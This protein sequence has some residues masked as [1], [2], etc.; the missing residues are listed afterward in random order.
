MCQR[1]SE[2]RHGL[3]FRKQALDRV[4][5]VQRHHDPIACHRNYALQLREVL[6]S[7]VGQ[8]AG[9]TMFGG[10]GFAFAP[11]GTLLA[12]TSAEASLRIVEL[13]PALSRRRKRR[14]PC[15]LSEAVLF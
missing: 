4:I 10:S 12:T 6:P 3:L 5:K 7:R 8:M 15:Y 2:A 14:Y 13:D 9:G 11:D 1:G